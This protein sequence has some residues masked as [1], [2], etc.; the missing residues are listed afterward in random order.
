MKLVGVTA[1]GINVRNEDSRNLELHDIYGKVL[2]DYFYDVASALVDEY[3]KNTSLENVFAHNIVMKETIFNTAEQ[4][5]YDILYLRVKTGEYGEESEIVNS[6]TGKTTHTKSPTEADVLPF[7]CCIMV[8]CGEYSEGIILIQ[9]LGRNGITSIIKQK[10]NEYIRIIDSQLRIVM[11][12]VVP[13]Q[14]MERL[15]TQGVLKSIRLIRFNIP[16]DDADRFGLDRNTKK[17]SQEI[18]IKKPIGFIK[19]KYENIMECMRGERDFDKIIEIEDF[20]IDDLKMEFGF[21]KRVKTIS[22]KGLD[23]I[24]INEDVTSEVDTENGIPVFNSL[25]RVM[26]EIGEDYLQARG[27]IE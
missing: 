22:M 23:K 6:N 17:S 10:L 26:K 4:P 8:P 12:P 19:N 24:V 15:L 1:Y 25:C 27:L 5:I 14:Y 18:V 2:I 20:E 7:G 16:D 9:S 21:G 13:R 3:K 11:N